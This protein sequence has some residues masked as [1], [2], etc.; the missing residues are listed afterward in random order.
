MAVVSS[1]VL[2]GY[3]QE[4]RVSPQEE[5]A[6]FLFNGYLYEDQAHFIEVGGR[7]S[8]VAP[9]EYT[10]ELI[11]QEL[12]YAYGE[13]DYS[14]YQ[15]KALINIPVYWHVIRKNNGNGNVGN[16]KISNSMAVL[17]AAFNPY[18]F[19]FNFKSTDR[20][21]NT[22]WFNMGFGSNAERNAK[23]ALR[24]GGSK[25]LNVYTT[26]GD[27]L[28]GWATF[29]WEYAGDPKLDGVV[30][31][32]QSVPGG[33]AA[34]YN[35]GDTL[36]HEVGHWLGLYHTFQGGCSASNDLVDDTPREQSPAFGCPTGRDTCAQAG[37][38]PITNYM[39]YTDDSC[40]FEFTVGQQDRMTAAF[41]TYRKP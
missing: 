19:K 18:G 25:A 38:D 39:D 11:E 13:M 26:N 10:K 9:D 23:T 5:D 33:N 32:R 36:V 1:L 16:T 28:L 24:K 31:Y 8:T 21:K 41:N 35:E 17:N 7:C 37:L 14:N 22:N 2:T 4:K 34:P 6:G 30:I 27:G 3:A 29:P 15:Q 40:M 20:T 12:S